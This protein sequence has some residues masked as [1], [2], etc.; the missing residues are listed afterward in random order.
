MWRSRRAVSERGTLL[1]D[2]DVVEREKFLERA[3]PAERS[4]H[5]LTHRV[6]ADTA[7]GSSDRALLR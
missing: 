3:R 5:I 4:R 1:A 2:A 7:A 6:E